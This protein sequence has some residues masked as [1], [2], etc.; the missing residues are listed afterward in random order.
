LTS[1]PSYT[2]RESTVALRKVLRTYRSL[3]A[4]SGDDVDSAVTLFD[5][6]EVL[7]DRRVLTPRQREA[8]RLNLLDEL[9]VAD[10]AIK[11]GITPRSVYQTV[12]LGVRRLLVFLQTQQYPPN[13]QH[14]PWTQREIDEVIA[15]NTDLAEK[16]A[17]K[18]G[19]ST[20]A[21]HQ[22]RA[23]L[24]KDG[25]LFPAPKRGRPVAGPRRPKGKVS[26]VSMPDA[27]ASAEGA[28]A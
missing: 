17:K 11:M 20:S 22:M 23:A 24:R 18:L 8:I 13:N 12:Y 19:R 21:V 7:E 9:S 4:S 16:T 10:T 5:L 14:R 25:L 26:G 28:R 3:L 2:W 1:K 6:G 27:F 15:G